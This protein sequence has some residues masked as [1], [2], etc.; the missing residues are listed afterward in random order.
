MDHA[1]RA[2]ER[3]K[4]LCEPKRPEPD[5]ECLQETSL[6]FQIQEE[7]KKVLCRIHCQFTDRLQSQLTSTENQITA[8]KNTERIRCLFVHGLLKQLAGDQS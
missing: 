4:I 2:D 5:I 8:H 3:T 1:E 7:K 6:S